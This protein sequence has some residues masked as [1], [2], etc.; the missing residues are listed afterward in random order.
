VWFSPAPG[1]STQTMIGGC[2]LKDA[3]DD[4]DDKKDATLTRNRLTSC[5]SAAPGTIR[6]TQPRQ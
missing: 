6:L 3:F 1:T 4:D 5:L 2:L